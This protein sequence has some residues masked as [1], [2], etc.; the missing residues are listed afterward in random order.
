MNDQQRI[1]ILNTI[2]GQYESAVWLRD[3]LKDVLKYR[4]ELGGREAALATLQEQHDALQ[5]SLDGLTTA[6]QAKEAACEQELE[7]ARQ[8]MARTREKLAADLH[9]YEAQ[10]EAR[11]DVLANQVKEAQALLKAKQEALAALAKKH[12]QV[13]S[14][15]ALAMQRYEDYKASLR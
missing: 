2:I 8:G 3:A 10:I 14:A 6:F 7:A 1:D 11:K 9:D 13:E 15:H 5:R 4:D 12:E